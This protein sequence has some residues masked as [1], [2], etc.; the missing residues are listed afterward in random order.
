MGYPRTMASSRIS[1]A[2]VA[3][4]ERRLAASEAAR[5]DAETRLAEVEEARARLERLLAQMRRATFRAKSEKR[6]PDQHNLPFED[7]EAAAG[8]LAAASE[9]ADRALGTRRKAPRAPEPNKGHLPAHLPRIEQVIEPDAAQDPRQSHAARHR[10]AHALELP[11]IVKPHDQGRSAGAYREIGHVRRHQHRHRQGPPV[12]VRAAVH[13]GPR[14]PA[15]HHRCI[16]AFHGAP[17]DW[18][19]GPRSP[20]GTRRIPVKRL[21]GKGGYVRVMPTGGNQAQLREMAAAPQ[22]ARMA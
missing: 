5:I 6:D 21:G 17:P 1:A 9:A 22:T 7:L 3:D 16:Q 11:R 13:H 10:R 2:R 12:R 19:A 8:M 15:S 14:T 18:L 4:L 20:F